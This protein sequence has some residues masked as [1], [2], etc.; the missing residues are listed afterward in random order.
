MAFD[1]N[2][3]SN[4]MNSFNLL[5]NMGYKPQAVPTDRTSIEGQNM[6]FNIDEANVKIGI[7]VQH[8]EA[9]LFDRTPQDPLNMKDIKN[10]DISVKNGLA[11]IKDTDL[12]TTVS[13]LV[14]EETKNVVK[15]VNIAFIPGNQIK[16]EVIGKKFL[17]FNLTVQGMA[18]PNPINN[19]VRF[20]PEKINV[21][22]IPVK[23]IMDFFGLEIGEL[24]KINNK[25]GSVFTSG[26]SIYFSPQK[27][28]QEPKIEGNV[29]GLKTGLGTLTVML[30]ND[31]PE[32][33]TPKP[34]YG[35]NNYLTMRGGN[36][37]FSGF[38]LLNTDLALVDGTPE[39]DFDLINDPSKK[40]ITEG[41]VTI[42]EEFIA[43]ALK[44]KAGGG[45]MKDMTFNMPNGVGKLKA[46]M[47]GFLPVSL[48]LNFGNSSTGIL[49]VT[50]DKG[51]VLGFI[52]LP[53][54]MLRKTLMKETEGQI[55]GNGVTVD[56]GKLADLQTTPF[57]NV[58]SENGKLI[59]NM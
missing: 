46:K 31:T 49:K 4:D 17:K 25:K 13:N 14:R 5:R 21:N 23:K 19:V 2:K 15:N 41:Q 28:V 30:G 10:V 50:P 37:D 9:D 48:D 3:I 35:Q 11:Q 39:N 43:T 38:N 44:Q 16:A 6:A 57:K 7:K 27:L 1:N 29:T 55:E 40:Y 54:S 45:S 26:D 47:W 20:T 22:G 36:V 18:H 58:R 51:K 24:I 59:L 53:N 34:V 42:P 56:L 32:N 12:T 8:F 52:P 33:Y